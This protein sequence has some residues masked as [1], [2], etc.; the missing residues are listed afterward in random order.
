LVGF[1]LASVLQ[2]PLTIVNFSTGF[3][4]T[5]ISGVLTLTA[6]ATA[7][8]PW[9]NLSRPAG[10]TFTWFAQGS[11]SYSDLTNGPLVIRDSAD[12]TAGWKGLV[13]AVPGTN[14]SLVTQ[15]SFQG[16]IA[17]T[18]GPLFGL[19]AINGSGA[20]VGFGQQFNDSSQSNN[21]VN[22]NITRWNSS[23]SFNSTAIKYLAGI[24]NP[25]WIKLDFVQSTGTFTFSVSIDGQ[26]WDVVGTETLGSF[27][28]TLTAVGF[29]GIFNNPS[30]GY[31]SSVRLYYWS[32]L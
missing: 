26:D 8:V 14:F 4:G 32:G 18:N 22:F 25:V 31:S 7:A 20:V 3:T 23:S 21:D 11:A 1:E 12:G 24:N 27:L 29:A 5:L 2:S 30:A 17:S 6:T 13:K 9:V 19:I 10:S 28:T 16:P 15:V